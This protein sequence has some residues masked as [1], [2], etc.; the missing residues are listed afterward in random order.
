MHPC[1]AGTNLYS[2]AAHEMGHALG[3][4]HSTVQGALMYPWYQ[5]YKPNLQLNWDD[6]RK[7]QYLYGKYLKHL[8]FIPNLNF[9]AQLLHPKI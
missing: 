8:N 6:L 5:G 7:I 3:L 9:F 4:V 2:V 1:F